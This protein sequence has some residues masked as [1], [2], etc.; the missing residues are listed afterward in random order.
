MRGGARHGCR[1][2]ET[3]IRIL[4]FDPRSLVMD[5]TIVVIED[6]P[7]VRRQ[8]MEILAAAGLKVIDFESGD[9]ALAYIEA[10]LDEVAAVF[11][12][13]KLM[14]DADGAR[15]AGAITEAHPTIIVVVTC[16]LRNGLAVRAGIAHARHRQALGGARCAQCHH[17]CR[18]GRLTRQSTTAL[19]TAV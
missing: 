5:R 15:I 6:E 9:R 16:R 8:T 12:D 1:P 14:G 18:T 3:S 4:P 19:P 10:N 7:L 13:V 11:C 2:A 17:R